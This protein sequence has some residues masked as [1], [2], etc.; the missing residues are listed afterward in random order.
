MDPLWLPLRS[1]A[2][3]LDSRKGDCL[4]QLAAH[5]MGEELTEAQAQEAKMLAE[6]GKVTPA[7]AGKGSAWLFL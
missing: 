3:K 5:L 1:H 7:K 6:R 4:C 2:P